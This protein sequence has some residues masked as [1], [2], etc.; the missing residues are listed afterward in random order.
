[1]IKQLE[2]GAT[3]SIEMNYANG[4]WLQIRDRCALSN[5]SCQL[6]KKVH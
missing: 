6:S 1:M 5:Q 4:E 3:I 2:N